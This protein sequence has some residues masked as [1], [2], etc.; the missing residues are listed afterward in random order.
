MTFWVKR[1]VHCGTYGLNTRGRIPFVCKSE[2]SGP[3]GDIRPGETL[4]VHLFFPISNEATLLALPLGEATE[5]QP[6]LTHLPLIV[7]RLHLFQSAIYFPSASTSLP[8]TLII[9]ELRARVEM[10]SNVWRNQKRPQGNDFLACSSISLRFLN[11]SL[12][13]SL[14]DVYV[15]GWNYW[16]QLGIEEDKTDKEEPFLLSKVPHH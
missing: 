1:I 15:W 3:Q 7:G 11:L 16:S 9:M 4:S 6:P 2:A 5:H 13:P 14:G 12:F 8:S 10:T